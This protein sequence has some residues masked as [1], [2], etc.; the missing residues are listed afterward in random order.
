MG[1]RYHGTV[2]KVPGDEREISNLSVFHNPSVFFL[3]F[4]K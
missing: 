1:G 2:A 3:R 4:H